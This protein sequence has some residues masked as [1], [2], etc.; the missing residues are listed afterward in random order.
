MPNQEIEEKSVPEPDTGTGAPPNFEA[1]F[2]E[3]QQKADE[4]LDA[5]LRA[6][7]DLENLRKRTQ[8][9]IEG[10]H[11]YAL[12]RISHELL[13]VRDSMELGLLT[14]SGTDVNPQVLKEGIELTLKMLVQVME[15]FNIKELNPQN[16]KF[17]SSY[18]Q[19]VSLQESDKLLPNTVISVMQKGYLLGDRL[20]RPAMVVVSRAMTEKT[21]SEPK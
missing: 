16:E 2:H 4:H 1:L 19:A 17:D 12:E 7:A 21:N 3:A 18:H 8:K 11:K 10:A 5:L 20:L 15:R 14:A 6:R 9:D 13:A